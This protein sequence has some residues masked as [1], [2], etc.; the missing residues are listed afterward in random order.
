MQSLCGLYLPLI[1]HCRFGTVAIVTTALL[2]CLPAGSNSEAELRAAHQEGK[3]IF[4]IRTTADVDMNNI[5]TLFGFVCNDIKYYNA[6]ISF[7]AEMRMLVRD[8]R[9]EV[10]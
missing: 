10:P 8:L 9:V 4:P 1:S 6:V 3:P 7:E 2:H 5:L